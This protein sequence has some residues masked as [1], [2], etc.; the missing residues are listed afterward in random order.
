MDGRRGQVGSLAHY[1]GHEL[2]VLKIFSE[3]FL[4]IPQIYP[5][6]LEYT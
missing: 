2:G 4:K 3:Y 1:V 6:M 5:N